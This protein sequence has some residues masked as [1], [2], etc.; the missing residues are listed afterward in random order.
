METEMAWGL[1][2][3]ESQVRPL[4]DLESVEEQRLIQ[5]ILEGDLRASR[6]F[7]DCYAPMVYKYVRFRVTSDQEAQDIAAQVFSRVLKALP[8]YQVRSKPTIAWILTFACEQ[9]AASRNS[10]RRSRLLALLPWR[11]KNGMEGQT[12]SDDQDELCRALDGLS[13]E[14]QLIIYFSFIEES[15]NQEIAR[16]LGITESA[17]RSAKVPALKQM[18]KLLNGGR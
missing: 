9:V 17:V 13:P 10:S 18:G 4:F 12:H 7:Y 15:S 8:D 3:R 14:Q 1:V 11:R 16:F 6:R 5:Q 2:H